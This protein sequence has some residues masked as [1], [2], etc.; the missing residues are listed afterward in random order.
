MLATKNYGKR[1]TIEESISEEDCREY[2]RA[3]FFSRLILPNTQIRKTM[4]ASSNQ[5]VV[6][7]KLGIR[8]R[9][10]KMQR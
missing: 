3:W 10:Q 1:K 9:G 4:E 6:R 7:R 5:I 2:F 8:Q